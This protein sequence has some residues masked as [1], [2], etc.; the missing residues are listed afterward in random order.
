MQTE[1]H[2]EERDEQPY[3]GIRSSV[4]M[5]NM[6]EVLP[7]LHGAVFA[8]LD[9]KGIEPSGPPFWRYNVID[10]AS[11]MEVEVAVP[12]SSPVPGGGDIIAGSLPSGRYAVL[13]HTGHPDTLVEAHAALQ[14]WLE[15]QGLP[16]AMNESDRGDEFD[17][18]I[19]IYLTDP[20]E[21]P[22]MNKWVTE[23]A[24]LLVS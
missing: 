18:R 3:V 5:E 17:C 9:G 2:L 12:V 24:Y 10:M 23:V 21:E 1:P 19:E 11:E 16:I 7:P 4:T 20:D 8:W 6:G 13:T 15:E 14:A 22:D